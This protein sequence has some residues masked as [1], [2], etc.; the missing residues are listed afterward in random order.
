MKWNGMELNVNL[1]HLQMLI[2]FLLKQTLVIIRFINRSRQTRKASNLMLIILPIHN[3]HVLLVTLISLFFYNLL[4]RFHNKLKQLTT[5]MRSEKRV[6]NN[7]S[8]VVESTSPSS[9]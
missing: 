9:S 1:N 4:L 7:R 8:S 3:L 5:M 2:N 6:W